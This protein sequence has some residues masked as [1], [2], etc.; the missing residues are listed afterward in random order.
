MDL[1]QASARLQCSMW[2]HISDIVSSFTTLDDKGKVKCFKL[3]I[4]D[5]FRS[6]TVCSQTG[7]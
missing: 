7:C 6:G 2:N 4:P 5:C 1:F 3:E